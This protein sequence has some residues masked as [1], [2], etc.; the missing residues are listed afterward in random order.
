MPNPDYTQSEFEPRYLTQVEIEEP[1]Q[2][3]HDFFDYANLPQ[4]RTHLWEWLKLTVSGT[5]HKESSTDRSNLLYFF[6]KL[7]Q[8]VEAAHILHKKGKYA[9]KT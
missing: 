1:Y 5:F 3:M 2:V 7:E 9:S 8:L 4:V 6:D